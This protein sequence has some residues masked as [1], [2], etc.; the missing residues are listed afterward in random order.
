MIEPK[1]EDYANILTKRVPT[2]IDND[3]LELVLLLSK[4]I[5]IKY[6]ILTDFQL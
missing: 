2:Y 1:N 3:N 4:N 6:I 5:V